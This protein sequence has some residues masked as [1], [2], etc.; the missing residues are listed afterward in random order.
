MQIFVNHETKRTHARVWNHQSYPVC[1]KYGMR[2][3]KGD[4]Q[5]NGMRERE[6]EYNMMVSFIDGNNRCT[7]KK[8]QRVQSDH[9]DF[10]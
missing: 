5:Q 9:C 3:R 7:R 6:R 4:F 2:E 10:F 1:Q 8:L